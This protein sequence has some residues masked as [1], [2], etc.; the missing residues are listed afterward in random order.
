[1]NTWQCLRHFLS[2]VSLRWCYTSRFLTPI[3][4]P[5]YTR[6]LLT[7]LCCGNGMLH[8]T[9]FNATL[10]AALEPRLLLDKYGGQWVK[11]T[12][13]GNHSGSVVSGRFGRTTQLSSHR[14]ADLPSSS[15]RASGIVISTGPSSSTSSAILF[16]YLTSTWPIFGS[17][18]CIL[19]RCCVKNQR[20]GVLHA[21]TPTKFGQQCCRFFNRFEKPATCYRNKMLR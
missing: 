8:E 16:V 2:P 13:A 17:L 3:F 15:N 12:A 14:T 10:L 21:P 5:C 19:G 1:M 9:I 7:Q 4:N 18:R 20:R 6:Q 11:K